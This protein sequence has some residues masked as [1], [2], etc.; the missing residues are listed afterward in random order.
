MYVSIVIVVQLLLLSITCV[1]MMEAFE[2]LIDA[3]YGN[4]K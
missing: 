3:K 1:K 2:R 4:G